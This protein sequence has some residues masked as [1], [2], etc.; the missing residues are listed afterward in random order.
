MDVPDT[1]RD[2]CFQQVDG[3]EVLSCTYG[4][5]N[6]STTVALVGD[7]KMDQWLPAFQVLA[8]QNDWKILIAAKASCPFT[9][10]PAVR[11]TTRASSTPT[12]S[13]GT[14]R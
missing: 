10:A 6:A 13:T 9:S 5:P 8:E 4:N 12:A 11:R 1:N 14:G 7:S 2:K 3:A